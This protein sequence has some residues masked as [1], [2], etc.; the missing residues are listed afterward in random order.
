MRTCKVLFY[1]ICIFSFYVLIKKL[2]EKNEL[3][4][5]TSQVEDS[6]VNSVRNNCNY[7]DEI[8][9]KQCESFDQ[10]QQVNKI[11]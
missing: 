5:N 11:D 10:K 6:S 7:S 8:P 1:F 3:L 2:L 9:L 4:D